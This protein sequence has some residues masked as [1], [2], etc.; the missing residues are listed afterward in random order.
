MDKM[1]DKIAKAVKTIKAAILKSQADVL[2]QANSSLL[3]LYYGIGR[4]VSANSREGTW[5]TGAI[6][7]ISDR[8]QREMPGL[9]GF[10]E[11]NIKNM[12]MFYEFWSPLIDR[13]PAAAEF[14]HLPSDKLEIEMALC[15]KMSTM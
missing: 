9:R 5:G 8:L 11:R 6:S 13:Q 15:D 3:A 10:G 2:R 14:R 12:R 1:T 7:A 4:Y